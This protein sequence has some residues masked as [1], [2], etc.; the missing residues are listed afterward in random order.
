MVCAEERLTHI[1]NGIELA[2]YDVTGTIGHPSIRV[3]NWKT[4]VSWWES[5]GGLARKK[6]LT[7]PSTCWLSCALLILMFE[8]HLVG[9]GPQ[10]TKLE[11]LGESPW[12]W[13]I[14]QILGLARQIRNGSYPAMDVLLLPSHTE[15]LPNAVLEAMTMGIPVAATDVGGV[16]D[17]LD[18]GHCGI[19]L[20]QDHT[21]WSNRLAYLFASTDRRRTIA[22]LARRRIEEHYTFDKRMGRV[23]DIYRNVLAG[24]SVQQP[25]Q[26]G[27]RKAA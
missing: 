1:S 25:T 26:P 9:D 12:R 27:L 3:R 15:G 19:I 17:L 5:W 22:R 6:G 24:M 2:E 16:A 10:R 13:P 21:N 23:F 18:H 14:G 4:T 8:L 11:E 7:V 20:S